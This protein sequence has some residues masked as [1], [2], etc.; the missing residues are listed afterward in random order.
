MVRAGNAAKNELNRIGEAFVGE[1]ATVP[2]RFFPVNPGQA[3]NLS[4]IERYDSAGW[5]GRR[6]ATGTIRAPT[7]AT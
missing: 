7:P 4:P 1:F 5:P 6:H 2:R 3:R